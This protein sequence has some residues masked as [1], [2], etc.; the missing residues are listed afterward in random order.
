MH[1]VIFLQPFLIYFQKQPP[2]MFY[3]KVLCNKTP[4]TLLKKRLWHSSF[5]LAISFSLVTSFLF[6]FLSLET[7]FLGLSYSERQG[8]ARCLTN[9][10]LK[11]V[12]LVMYYKVKQIKSSMNKYCNKKR[13]LSIIKKKGA[14]LIKL[15]RVR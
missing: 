1:S 3:K 6:N 4:V 13:K 8:S 2:E 14:F 9:G 12:W 15:E 11:A 7:F 10:T 5:P